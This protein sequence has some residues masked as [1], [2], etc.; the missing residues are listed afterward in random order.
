MG[1]HFL[2]GCRWRTGCKR[3]TPRRWRTPET[4]RATQQEPSNNPL[5]FATVPK[6]EPIP[7][8]APVPK[9]GQLRGQL[10]RV[11]RDIDRTS[12]GQ[13]R[14]ESGVSSLFR[15]NSAG[16]L[17]EFL[18]SSTATW[19]EFRRHC[20]GIPEPNP[21]AKPSLKPFSYPYQKHHDHH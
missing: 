20:R 4:R 8:A 16:Q 10:V 6:T 9:L 5:G 7:K 15:A 19:A 11:P 3:R 13:G 18:E 2:Q 17:A 1:G 12:V 14:D 21:C